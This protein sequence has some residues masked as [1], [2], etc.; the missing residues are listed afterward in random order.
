[1]LE[2]GGSSVPAAVVRVESESLIKA[3]KHAAILVATCNTGATRAGGDRKCRRALDL[4]RPIPN[5]LDDPADIIEVSFVN[6]ARLPKGSEYY[7]QTVEAWG[8]LSWAKAHW[9]SL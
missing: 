7:A 3:N 4:F 9:L 1:M 8:S 5:Y 2:V 6:A